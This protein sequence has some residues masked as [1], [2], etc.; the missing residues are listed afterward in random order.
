MRSIAFSCA[1]TT[2]GY[3]GKQRH[4]WEE[5]TVRLV[6]IE[7]APAMRPHGLRAKGDAP[8]LQT[9]RKGVECRCL[10]H[11]QVEQLVAWELSPAA[12]RVGSQSISKLG[13]G[14]GYQHSCHAR[15]RWSC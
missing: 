1:S 8:R 14:W 6:L 10:E 13:L 3:T 11:G 12:L 9:H 5:F 7:Q 2:L 15:M 4:W